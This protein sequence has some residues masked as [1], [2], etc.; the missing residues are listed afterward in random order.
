MI[1]EPE[2][3]KQKLS[4]PDTALKMIVEMNQAYMAKNEVLITE[5]RHKDT[6]IAELEGKLVALE[7][8]LSCP[9]EGDTKKQWQCDFCNLLKKGN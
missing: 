5:L 9:G 4:P 2:E 8:K 3:P 7:R 6:I 1:H